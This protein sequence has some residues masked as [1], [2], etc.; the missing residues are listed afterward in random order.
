[1]GH[2]KTLWIVGDS[3]SRQF[4]GALSCILERGTGLPPRL[5][6]APRDRASI[7]AVLL[8]KKGYVHRLNQE[9][10]DHLKSFFA[11]PQCILVPSATHPNGHCTVCYVSSM[12]ALEG[13]SILTRIGTD[14]AERIVINWGL[15]QARHKAVPHLDAVLA[16][17]REFCRKRDGRC[18]RLVWRETSAQHFA[19]SAGGMYSKGA[20]QPCVA[21]NVSDYSHNNKLNL[22]VEDTLAAYPEVL[23]LP[24]WKLT[25]DRFDAHPAVP[26][27]GDCTHWCAHHPPES[28]GRG[29]AWLRESSVGDLIREPG[30]RTQVSPGGARGVGPRVV[31]AAQGAASR[32]RGHRPG[33]RALANLGSV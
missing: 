29:F 20:H 28:L 24:V 8:D 16:G 26:G 3:V 9:T 10:G 30:R 25:A 5:L 4:F 7:P 1:V 19:G 6:E 32:E 13:L 33:A 15:H 14:P 12:V 18:A 31:R 17:Y 11:K 23:K 2:N 27:K 21:H 22:E